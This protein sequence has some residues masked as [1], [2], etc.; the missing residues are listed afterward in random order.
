[1]QLS[2]RGGLVVGLRTP[3]GQEV[4]NPSKAY[5]LEPGTQLLYLAELPLRKPPV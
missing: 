2:K 5:R 1:M 4:I 3:A